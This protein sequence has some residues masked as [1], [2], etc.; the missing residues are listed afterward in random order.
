[1]DI[2][3]L[4]DDNY[5]VSDLDGET[6][7]VYIRGQGEHR[8]Y[9]GTKGV[10]P[11]EIIFLP[12]GTYQLDT[13]PPRLGN[14]LQDTFYG[15]LKLACVAIHERIEYLAAT[16]RATVLRDQTL[17][18]LRAQSETVAVRDVLAGPE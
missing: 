5:I 11:C 2:R 9:V 1:M 10:K 14:N 12:G 7:Q 18:I 4:G 13:L 16:R 15:A 17:A 3:Y 8:L 6:F